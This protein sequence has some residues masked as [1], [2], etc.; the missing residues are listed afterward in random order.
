MGL[1][2]CKQDSDCLAGSVC[3]PH[4]S[5]HWARFCGAAGASGAEFGSGGQKQAEEEAA[6]A[7]ADAKAKAE[8]DAKAA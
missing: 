4:Y 5:L 7:A 6:K 2:R 3:N 8:A 1:M